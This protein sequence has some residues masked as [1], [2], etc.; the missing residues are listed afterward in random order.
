[1]TAT[2]S[3]GAASSRPGSASLLWAKYL[4]LLAT[5]PVLT[6]AGTSATLNFLQEAVANALATDPNASSADALIKASKMA[7]YGLLVSGPLGHYLYDL[8]NKVF[9]GSSL[10]S[11]VGQLVGANVAVAPIQNAVY[12]AAMAILAGRPNVLD[13]VERGF[14]PLMKLTWAVFPVVQLI[15][16]KFVPHDLWLPFFNIVSFVFGVYTNFKIKQE[17]RR[18]QIAAGKKK[19]GATAKDE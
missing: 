6:K 16:V 2:S 4:A 13:E 18:R 19:A 15:A 17:H 9:D 7:A 5:R 14:M 8:L 1:M 10:A 12:L 3:S 11:M